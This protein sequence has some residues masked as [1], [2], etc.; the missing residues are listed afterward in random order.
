MPYRESVD[1]Q[2]LELIKE[3]QA[4][5][6][7]KEFFLVGGTA[8]ALHLN[9]RQSV[10]IDL[11]SN[12]AFD[13]NNLLEAIQQDF[14]YQISHTATNTLKGSI[15]NIKVDLIAHRYPYLNPP[16]TISGIQA[17]SLPDITAMKLNAIVTSGQ[18]SKDF[19]DIYYLADYFTVENMLSFYKA[20]YS[21]EKDTFL[22]KSL[23][24]FDEVDLSDWPVLIKD[25][26]LKWSAIKKKLT[27][28][29]LNYTRQQSKGLLG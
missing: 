5:E 20:K 12:T 10:D 29:V 13:T 17:L 8:L 23:I 22:L 24:Y 1:I 3:L 19:I 4:R 16:V 6:Y 18:R 25:R 9:H 28:L 21:Q 14:S 26:S 15:H 7:L 11:F 27:S 2:T